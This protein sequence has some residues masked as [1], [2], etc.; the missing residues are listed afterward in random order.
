MYAFL[1]EIIPNGAGNGT[2]S[3][4]D[5]PGLQHA[6]MNRSCAYC[7]RNCNQCEGCQSR[8]QDIGCSSAPHKSAMLRRT[9]LEVAPNATRSL[10][11]HNDLSDTYNK[12]AR[13]RCIPPAGTG[14]TLTTRWPKG[15]RQR[16]MLNEL[17]ARCVYRGGTSSGC[18]GRAVTITPRSNVLSDVRRT[19]EASRTV[20][21][22]RFVRTLRRCQCE[23]Q[24]IYLKT[25]I[26]CWRM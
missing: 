24:N 22:V 6:P 18:R 12:K 5:F 21:D 2:S 14:L 26:E 19:G 10:D 1:L 4:K 17:M 7:L 25:I 16:G 8:E 11:L 23:Q 9:C 20:R 3:K 13:R 15:A